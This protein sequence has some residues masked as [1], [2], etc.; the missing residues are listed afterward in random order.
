MKIR[1][2]DAYRLQ[3]GLTC[4]SHLTYCLQVGVTIR[5]RHTR[6]NVD[7]AVT[8]IDVDNKEYSAFDDMDEENLE[9]ISEIINQI[10][11]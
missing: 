5:N 2:L 9:K 8:V 7:E 1:E 10:L 4:F 11:E 6:F 3:V